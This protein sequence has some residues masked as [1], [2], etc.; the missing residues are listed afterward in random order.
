ML[1]WFRRNGRDLPWRRTRDP[2]EILVS[3]V[4]LQQTQVERVREYYGRFLEE[5]PTV[6]DLAAAKPGRVRESWDGLGYYA[7]ARNLHAAARTIIRQYQ[8]RF[9]RRLEDVLALPGVGR[10]TAGAVVSFA[11]GEP[12]P[13]LDTNVRRVLSR[14]FVRRRATSPA[15][16][17]RQLWAL[18][19]AVIPAGD[20]W[21]MNQAL[22]D[23]GATVCTARNPHCERC[24]MRLRCA[25][26]ARAATTLPG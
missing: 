22:M 4:M 23:F 9:P 21:T 11:Y 15:K 6:Q 13:I 10:Y 3:E 7:R 17:E 12:A 8:G 2:Y 26:Y 25:Y 19:E 16:E 1:R 20:A 24:P 14:F 5:Y 18:A